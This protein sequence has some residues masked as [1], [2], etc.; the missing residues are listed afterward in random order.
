[1][2]IMPITIDQVFYPLLRTG[3]LSARRAIIAVRW[4]PDPSWSS[5]LADFATIL[6]IPPRRTSVF[7]FGLV[8]C[9]GSSR[10][11]F[12]WQRFAVIGLAAAETLHLVELGSR[13]GWR[14]LQFSYRPCVGL[15]RCQHLTELYS[16]VKPI[17][18]FATDELCLIRLGTPAQGEASHRLIEVTT[19]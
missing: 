5:R 7:F 12:L 13:E 11:R 8:E 14:S 16:N 15:G 17:V 2:S 3:I 6:P 4:D 19:Y 1:M 18:C 9:F 10:S